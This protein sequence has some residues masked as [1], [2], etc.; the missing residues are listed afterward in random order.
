VRVWDGRQRVE[1]GVVFHQFTTRKKHASALVSNCT[2]DADL[3][4]NAFAA[5][6]KNQIKSYLGSLDTQIVQKCP[7]ILFP[8]RS[9]I[10]K[11]ILFGS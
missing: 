3:K 4:Q 6:L 7:G 5:T 11:F 2:K 1:K 9:K 8:L 10:P